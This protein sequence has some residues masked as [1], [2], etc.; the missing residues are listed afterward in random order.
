MEVKKSKAYKCGVK[1][2]IAG[3]PMDSN[4]YKG[5]SERKHIVVSR[6]EWF[7]GYL[8]TRTELRLSH[9]FEKYE[10]KYAKKK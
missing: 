5:N 3:D 7:H 10:K 9:I 8:D 6:I 4:P 2:C 1:N